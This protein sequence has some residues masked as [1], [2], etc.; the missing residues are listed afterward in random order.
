MKRWVSPGHEKSGDILPF[1]LCAEG[2]TLYRRLLRHVLQQLQRPHLDLAVGRLG[3]TVH[4]FAGL[5]R[6]IGN[7]NDS[8]TVGNR[9]RGN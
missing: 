5:E 4:Q 3:R 2:R 7:G 8:L 1:S 6:V 9:E